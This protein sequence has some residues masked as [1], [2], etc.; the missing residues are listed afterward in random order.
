M[1]TLIRV[2]AISMLMVFAAPV[3]SE[4]NKLSEIKYTGTIYIGR[5]FE[6]NTAAT[7]DETWFQKYTRRLQE[8]SQLFSTHIEVISCAEELDIESVQLEMVINQLDENIDFVVANIT[9]IQYV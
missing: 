4:A 1:T 9:L 3:Y 2:M 7:L 8:L 6:T 5:K